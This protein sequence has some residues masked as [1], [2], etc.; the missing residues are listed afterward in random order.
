MEKINLKDIILCIVFLAIGTII[1]GFLVVYH[2]IPFSKEVTVNIDPTNIISMLVTIILAVYVVGAISK[3]SEIERVEKDLLI[4]DLGEYKNKVQLEVSQMISSSDLLIFT[5]NEKM[6][7]IIQKTESFFI[8]LKDANFAN[9]YE[10]QNLISV[11]KDFKILFTDTS[12]EISGSVPVKIARNKITLSD[13]RKQ[14]LYQNLNK[15]DQEI[16]RLISRI[17]KN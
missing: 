2:P 1:G 10:S 12:T 9:D 4:K 13:V 7:T 16:H 11:L 14:E 15:F 17:N 5:V 6:K 3:N 8:I